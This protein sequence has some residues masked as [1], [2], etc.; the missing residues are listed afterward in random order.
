MSTSI[1]IQY[2]FTNE[3]VM[4]S[5]KIVIEGEGFSKTAYPD[6]FSPRGIEMKKGLHQRKPGWQLLSGS[7]WTIGYGRTGPDV[8]PESTTTKD[9][10]LFWLKH[11]VEEE[12]VWLQQRG[13]P[14]CAGLVSLIYNIGKYNFNKS[15]AYKAFQECR[16][17]DALVEMQGFNKAGGKVRPGLVKRRAKEA[18][19]VKDWLIAAKLYTKTNT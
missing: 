9:Q 3:D 15:K 5:I 17:D 6:P 12:L 1:K 14:P 13:V 18:K 7:P 10:E 8:R 2:K 16:W 4:E 11:R 19:L